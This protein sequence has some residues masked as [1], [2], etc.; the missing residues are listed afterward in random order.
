MQYSKL[1]HYHSGFGLIEVL[2][3]LTIVVVGLLAV[4]TFQSGLISQSGASKAK[5][6]AMALAQ[7]RVEEFRNYTDISDETAFDA[8]YADTSSDYTNDSAID[9]VNADF[10]RSEMITDSGDTKEIS[11]KVTWDDGQGDTQGVVLNSTL[12]WQEPRLVGDMAKELNDPYVPSPTGRAHLGE[13]ELPA[14]ASQDQITDNGDGTRLYDS[15]DGDLKLVDSTDVIVLTLEDACD[16]EGG[17]CTDFVKI[18]GRVYIDTSSQS[19]LNPGEVYVK[20]SDAAY[21]QRYYES[22][23]TTTLVSGD[24]TSALSTANG[25]YEYFD[26]TCYL[27]GGWHGNIG[28]LLDGGISQ[29]DKICLG[30]GT[31][32]DTSTEPDTVGTEIAARRAY[33]GMTYKVDDNGDMVTDD[34]GD[35]IY[36][37]I[38]IGDAVELPP[39]LPTSGTLAVSSDY[40][41][42]ATQTLTLY[43]RNASGDSVTETVMLDG[44]NAVAFSTDFE[45]IAKAELSAGTQGTVALTK[46]SST[47]LEM[48]GSTTKVFRY[49][50][51]FVVSSMATSD[52]DGYNC[53]INNGSDGPM[54]RT[55]AVVSG[56]DGARFAGNSGDFFCLNPSYV[57][58]YDTNQY[59]VNGNCPYDPTDGPATRHI[60]SG[61]VAIT[62]NDSDATMIGLVSIDTSDGVGNC[63]DLSFTFDGISTYTDSYTCDVYE[64]TNGWTG[65]V[66][67]S[68]NSADVLCDPDS[69][70]KTAITADSSGND[71]SCLAGN[72]VVISGTVT[73]SNSTKVLSA[74]TISDSN[75]SRSCDVG[76][77]GLSYEC[78]SYVFDTPT[79]NGTI[80]FTK[81]GGAFCTPS[82]LDPATGSD[83][84]DIAAGTASFAGLDSKMYTYDL[85]IANNSTSCP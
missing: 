62:G 7:A 11:V 9:G 47:I 30:D 70:T 51:D 19:N 61:T 32:Y 1:K 39:P 23:G 78:T 66:K 17:N 25:D 14:D 48:G 85:T 37:S 55:D 40:S 2:A 16:S 38:G 3:A 43:G 76:V 18:H 6:E 53:I 50:H 45:H 22:G 71:F 27:G 10:T 79:W 8:E 83:S 80:Q 34:N 28:I 21:C 84:F 31:I 33:R 41:L 13:G 4:A 24:T 5:A 60:L 74:A 75:G 49:S 54:R 58:T 59:A 73:T 20:A 64:W 36:Y 44:T 35:P 81:T 63:S 56:E 42:D 15:Q 69:I 68:E 72:V 82:A 52:T 57:D 77:D 29:S 46:D 67:V 12:T 65:Y 26:Y